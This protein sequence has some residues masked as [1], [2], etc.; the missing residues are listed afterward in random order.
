MVRG[1]KGRGK[2]SGVRGRRVENE[3]LLEERGGARGFEGRGKV[4]VKGWGSAGAGEENAGSGFGPA[5]GKCR[6][7]G[8]EVRER[9][10][11]M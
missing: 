6:G 8:S 3:N 5:E 10:L 9:E 7:G 1:I 2:R 11:E 4:V